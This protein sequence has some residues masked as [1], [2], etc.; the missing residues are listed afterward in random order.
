[1]WYV[2]LW[3]L[4]R[5]ICIVKHKAVSNMTKKSLEF[6]CAFTD[7]FS[8]NLKCGRSTQGRWNDSKSR[9]RERQDESVKIEKARRGMVLPW[10]LLFYSALQMWIKPSQE[11]VVEFECLM[12]SFLELSTGTQNIS[13]ALEMYL[14]TYNFWWR[15]WLWWHHF[16]GLVHSI[17]RICYWDLR[18]ANAAQ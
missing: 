3:T 2:F 11:A 9:E 1:V 16:H 18:A 17:V 14:L 6:C 7:A 13:N 5:K 15:Q 4:L 12:P 10:W 8:Y